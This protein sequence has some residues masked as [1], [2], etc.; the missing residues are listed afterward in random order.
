MQLVVVLV[1]VLVAGVRVLARHVVSKVAD[2]LVLEL[3]AGVMLSR[4][5]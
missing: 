5:L 2:V 3:V 1:L 4:S